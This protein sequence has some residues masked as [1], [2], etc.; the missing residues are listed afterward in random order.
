M[1]LPPLRFEYTPTVSY[2]R[3]LS[4]ED[5][6]LAEVPM[7]FE[8]FSLGSIR[9]DGVTHEHDVVIDRRKVGK[10]KTKPSKKFR[11]TFGHTPALRQRKDSLEVT[12]PT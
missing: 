12:P 11:D 6:I 2:I 8:E 7:R 1:E 5:I 10:R 4:A 9:I 3:T